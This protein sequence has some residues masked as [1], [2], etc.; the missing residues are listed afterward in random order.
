MSH[1]RWKKKRLEVGRNEDL[2]HNVLMTEL[3]NMFAKP[4]IRRRVFGSVGLFVRRK[5][6]TVKAQTEDSL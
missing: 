5:T 3:V 6:L 1:L 4:K 2:Y